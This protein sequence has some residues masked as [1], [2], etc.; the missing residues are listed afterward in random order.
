MISSTWHKRYKKNVLL[1]TKPADNKKKKK[2]ACM[3]LH[4]RGFQRLF[5]KQVHNMWQFKWCTFTLQIYQ[6]VDFK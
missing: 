3:I 5:G 6:S 4:K 2:L 1:F